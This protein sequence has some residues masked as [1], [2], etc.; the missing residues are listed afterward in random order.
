[1]TTLQKPSKTKVPRKNCTGARNLF[2]QQQRQAEAEARGKQLQRREHGR[3][4]NMIDV[5]E[6]ACSEIEDFEMLDSKKITSSTTTQ[7]CKDHVRSGRKIPKHT[8]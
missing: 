1:M 4:R 5:E 8:R 7:P 3:C 6:R 2:A